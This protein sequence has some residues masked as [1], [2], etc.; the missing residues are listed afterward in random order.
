MRHQ[1]FPDGS[2]DWEL[3]SRNDDTAPPSEIVLDE[4]FLEAGRFLALPPGAEVP[5]RM[6]A[7]PGAD[8]AI[9]IEGH[10][11][12][13][14]EALGTSMDDQWGFLHG[15]AAK[16]A[17]RGPPNANTLSRYAYNAFGI[18][19]IL[20]YLGQHEVYDAQVLLVTGYE[21]PIELLIEDERVAG[22]TV[23]D[24]SA[25]ALEV[26]SGKY[27]G[28]ESMGKI[29]L[30]KLDVSGLDPEF[31]ASE[32]A[33]LSEVQRDG[34]FPIG[35]IRRHFARIAD[36]RHLVQVD[37]ATDSFQ[38]A[39][40][41]FVLGSLYLGPVTVACRA[42]RPEENVGFIDYQEMLGDAVQTVEAQAACVIVA[43][44][45]LGEMRRIVGPSGRIVANVWA[46]PQSEAPGLVRMSDTPVTPKAFDEL[47]SGSL[48]LFSGN[49]QPSLPMALGH[50]FQW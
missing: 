4:R 34:R 29:I 32:I 21:S 20:T 49:P 42:N 12:L 11:S 28:H 37:L 9:P 15:R 19:N 17:T 45:A 3:Q 14:V 18:R 41:P 35:A 10:G 39:H 38:A 27:S 6:Y 30:R 31:Q 43:K 48:R 23:V 47:L 1:S 13:I 40:L 46:R 50:V 44:H 16:A 24:L 2:T 7:A 22:V 26:I 36:G 5:L 33:E 25:R 8:R